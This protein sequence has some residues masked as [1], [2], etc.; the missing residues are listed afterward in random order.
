MLV[1]APLQRGALALVR[2]AGLFYQ[3]AHAQVAGLH[4]DHAFR[5]QRQQRRAQAGGQRLVA[6][7]L[8]CAVVHRDSALP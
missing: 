3:C 4:A 5:L 8:Q 2:L 6:L 7:V 1:F